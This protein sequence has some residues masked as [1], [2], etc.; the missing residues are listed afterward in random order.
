MPANFTSKR[1]PAY[2]GLVDA[3]GNQLGTAANPL[4]TNSTAADNSITTAMLQD[5]SVTDDKLAN[6]KINVPDP[7]ISKMVIGTTLS[8]NVLGTVGYSQTPMADQLVMYQFGGQVA[9]ATPQVDGDATTKKYVDDRLATKLTATKAA[10][11]ANSTATDVAGLVSDFNA[12]LAKLRAAG[13]M[14]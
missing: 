13:I 8:T 1:N 4:Y 5:G 11:Q 2:V 10:A 7:L 9:V 14:A 6:P 12:L 3:D